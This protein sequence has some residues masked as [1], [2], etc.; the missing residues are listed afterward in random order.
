ME[1]EFELLI[2]RFETIHEDLKG[3]RVALFEGIYL[4]TVIDFF[5]PIFDFAFIISAERKS[6]GRT[7]NLK[8]LD[9]KGLDA[10]ILTDHRSFLEEDY[11]S[12]SE[13][14]RK[15]G[16]KIYD[17]FGIDMIEIHDELAATGYM[18]LYQWKEKVKN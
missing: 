13:I 18:N 3:K 9:V 17:L 8:D 10:V 4:E 15:E 1:R 14:C 7:V 5:D 12:V 11:H 6:G 16:V 2:N